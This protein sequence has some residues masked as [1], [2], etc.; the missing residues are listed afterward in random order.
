MANE[1]E[2]KVGRDATYNPKTGIY[3]AHYENLHTVSVSR[4]EP[5]K[6]PVMN[7]RFL[8]GYTVE[9]DLSAKGTKATIHGQTGEKRLSVRS[10]RPNEDIFLG[11][12]RS[13]LIVGRIG[14]AGLSGKEGLKAFLA[15][16]RSQDDIWLGTIKQIVQGIAERQKIVPQYDGLQEMKALMKRPD[17]AYDK[18]FSHLYDKTIYP[19]YHEKAK[20]AAH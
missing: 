14:K 2:L 7:S 19:A 4:D 16:G 8:G 1:D 10:P 13:T 11:V 12:N 18:D 6:N 3:T 15:E 9:L 17:F 20:Q 5:T